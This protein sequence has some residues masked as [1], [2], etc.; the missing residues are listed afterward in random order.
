MKEKDA[1]EMFYEQMRHKRHMEQAQHWF[2]FILTAVCAL[3]L[4]ICLFLYL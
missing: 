2:L 3:L 1:R 4:A